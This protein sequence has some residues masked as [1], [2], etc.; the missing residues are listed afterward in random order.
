MQE[1][2]ISMMTVI[3]Q[4]YNNSDSSNYSDSGKHDFHKTSTS[5]FKGIPDLYP[6]VI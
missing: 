2:I 1:D 3:A 6:I 4:N 5:Q